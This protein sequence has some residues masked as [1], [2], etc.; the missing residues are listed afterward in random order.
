MTKE[1]I[2]ANVMIDYKGEQ[3]F[4]RSEAL[5]AMEEYANPNSVP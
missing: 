3:I 5:E 1:Q 2:L 4:T